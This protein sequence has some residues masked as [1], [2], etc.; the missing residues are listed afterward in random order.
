MLNSNETIANV[1]WGWRR[2]GG[3]EREGGKERG[4]G[5]EREGG[6]EGG[7]GRERER[8]KMLYNLHFF[9]L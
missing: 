9:L 3:S 7:R 1:I 8:E 2:G 4:R 5:R 6:R